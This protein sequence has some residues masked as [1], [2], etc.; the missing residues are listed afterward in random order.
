MRRAALVVVVF[1]TLAACSGFKAFDGGST[2]RDVAVD[3]VPHDDV[4]SAIDASAGIDAIDV[5][6]SVALTDRAS[7]TADVALDT[8]DATVGCGEPLCGAAATAACDLSDGLT[9]NVVVGP[10]PDSFIFECATFTPGAAA[11]RL[12]LTTSRALY[13]DFTTPPGST[14]AIQL[15]RSS[16][17]G[18]TSFFVNSCVGTTG[19]GR[20]ALGT[21]PAGVYFVV[22]KSNGGSVRLNAVLM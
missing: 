2:T 19:T 12:T 20:D 11:V 13:I 4:V 17:C 7:D 18:T 8:S 10:A 9:H 14:S 16:A 21:V 1:T 15:Y 6:D 5:S 3:V 22:V